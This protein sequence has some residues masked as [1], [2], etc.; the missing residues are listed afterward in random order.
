MSTSNTMAERLSPELREQLRLLDASAQ[1]EQRWPFLVT[2]QAGA[3]AAAVLPVA[4]ELEVPVVNLACATLTP[5]QVLALAAHEAV[6]SIEPDGVAE[7]IARAAR[8]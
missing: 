1:R 8:P 7:A 5:A 4:P 3:S 6:V 2:L